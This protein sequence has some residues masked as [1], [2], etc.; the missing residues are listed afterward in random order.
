M[1]HMSGC[2]VVT[3]GVT[4]PLLVIEKHIRIEG[5]QELSLVETTQEQGF[6]DADIP[7]A[8]RANHPLMGRC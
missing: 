5:P 4:M 7:G 6:I 2:H 1:R 3:G 8:Q